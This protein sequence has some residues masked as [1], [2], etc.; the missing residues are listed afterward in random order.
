LLEAGT[1]A[2]RVEHVRVEYDVERAMRGIRESE[3]PD[4]F[5]EYLRTGGQLPVKQSS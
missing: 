1:G 2:V 3:L 4:D 5:A